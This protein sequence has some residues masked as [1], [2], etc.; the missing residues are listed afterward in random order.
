MERDRPCIGGI[1]S[2]VWTSIKPSHVPAETDANLVDP[3]RLIL[4]PGI[5]ASHDPTAWLPEVASA[6]EPSQHSFHV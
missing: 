6:I 2:E 3:S 1:G 4:V 5:L